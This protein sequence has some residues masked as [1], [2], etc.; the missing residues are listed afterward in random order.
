MC[1]I[2]DQTIMAQEQKYLRF[3]SLNAKWYLQLCQ[4]WPYLL[5]KTFKLI[6]ERL[7]IRLGLTVIYFSII[8]PVSWI[9]FIK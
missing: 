6:L 4:I 1:R 5:K 7:T 8:N 3:L 9:D 2:F